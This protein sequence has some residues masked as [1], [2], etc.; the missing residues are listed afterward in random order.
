MYPSSN[1]TRYLTA[2]Q[3]PYQTLISFSVQ[4]YHSTW[5]TI[6][7]ILP[8]P[9]SPVKITLTFN[10]HH[11]WSGLLGAFPKQQANLNIFSPTLFS[12]SCLNIYF[13]T[14]HTLSSVNRI[15]SI[16]AKY[17]I[18]GTEFSAQSASLETTLKESHKKCFI[19]WIEDLDKSIIVSIEKTKYGNTQEYFHL[20]SLN[21][22]LLYIW[23]G[24]LIENKLS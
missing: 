21:D 5:N 7:I 19:N 2:S 17:W 15:V 12:P 1:H 13:I 22:G 20:K 18:A 3:C 10:V 16:D 4:A 24:F 8:T 23:I 9:L 11:R 6:L 14:Y